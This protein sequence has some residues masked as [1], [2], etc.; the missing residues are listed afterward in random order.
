MLYS[1]LALVF[2]GGP[3]LY[4]WLA[5][6]FPGGPLLYSWLAVFPALFYVFVVFAKNQLVF[7]KNQLV[8]AKNHRHL[9]VFSKNHEYVE[10]KF[11]GFSSSLEACCIPG[12]LSWAHIVF[13]GGPF[14]YSWLAVFPAMFYVYS[15]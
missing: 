12:S 1:W 15:H 11:Y 5:L 8:F 6:V 2:P 13:P 3:L 10:L 7:A 9:L 14:L 4:S